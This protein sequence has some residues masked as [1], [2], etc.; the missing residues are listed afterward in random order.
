MNDE[1]F[2]PYCVLLR[3]LVGGLLDAGCRRA[4]LRSVN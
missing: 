3:W 1:L 2:A 4:S